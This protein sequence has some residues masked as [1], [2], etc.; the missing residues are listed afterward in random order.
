MLPAGP[1]RRASSVI[2]GIAAIFDLTGAV[3]FRLLRRSLPAAARPAPGRQDQGQETPRGQ[4]QETPRGQ[5][6]ETPRA[7]ALAAAAAQIQSAYREAVLHGRGRDGPGSSGADAGPGGVTL[8]GEQPPA[9][10]AGRRGPAGQ[11]RARPD[12]G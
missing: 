8:P 4:G 3:V 5:G 9:R 7:G 10:R 1:M 12:P 2:L 6:Q 11:H